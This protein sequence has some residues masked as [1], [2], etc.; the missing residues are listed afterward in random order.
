[1]FTWNSNL[2]RSY[3]SSTSLRNYKFHIIFRMFQF[4]LLVFHKSIV[5]KILCVYI[6]H[7]YIKYIKY[8][9]IKLQYMFLR[10][11]RENVWVKRQVFDKYLWN[12]LLSFPLKENFKWVIRK[13]WV[14][15]L[16]NYLNYACYPGIKF[17]SILNSIWMDILDIL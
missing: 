2:S 10:F 6:K 1:M 15:A 8:V 17:M 12:M 9:Y 11:Y 3:I 7:M 14:C 16:E 4:I 13:K 5:I